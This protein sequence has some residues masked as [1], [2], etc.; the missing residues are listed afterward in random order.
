MCSGSPNEAAARL[1]SF[2]VGAFIEIQGRKTYILLND[3][4]I[5]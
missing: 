1:E 5:H 3:I 4:Q 2:I